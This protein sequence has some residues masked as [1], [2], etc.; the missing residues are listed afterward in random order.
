MSA[1]LALQKDRD[2]LRLAMREV[3][4]RFRAL[5]TARNGTRDEG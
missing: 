4:V 1:F 3:G 5:G 2:Q